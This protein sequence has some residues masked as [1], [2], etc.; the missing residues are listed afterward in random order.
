MMQPLDRYNYD[1]SKTIIPGEQLKP[2]TGYSMLFA[3]PFNNTDV[4]ATS[5]PFEVKAVGSTY[6]PQITTSDALTATGGASGSSAP[7]AT[8][9][10]NHNGGI[11]NAVGPAFF[12][13]AGI[14]TMMFAF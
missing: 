3:N 2:G 5:Q 13:L 1:C 7:S 9:T 12:T 11:A 8:S 14:V 10:P 6:P 4:F